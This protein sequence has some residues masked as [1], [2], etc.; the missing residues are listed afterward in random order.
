MDVVVF[1][2]VELLIA[3]T[4]VSDEGISSLV[5]SDSKLV[6]LDIRGCPRVTGQSL[7]KL[8]EMKR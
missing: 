6:L 1:S 3:F 8:S 7:L 4:S 2:L 5:E